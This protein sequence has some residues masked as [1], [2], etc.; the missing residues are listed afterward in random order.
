MSFWQRLGFYR[1]RNEVRRSDFVFYLLLR[2]ISLLI[3]GLFLAFGIFLYQKSDLAL[4]KF[5]WKF[6]LDKN[7]DPQAQEFGALPFI[8]G[9]LVTSLLALIIALPVSLGAALYLTEVAPQRLRSSM[10]F[11]IE[12]LA[13]IPSVV[14][15]LWG[16]FV[17]APWM[18][19]LIQPF[20]GQHLG[21]LPFFQGPPFGIGILTAALILSIMIL[22]TM[23]AMIREVFKAVPSILR[24]GALSLGATRWESMRMAVL[25]TAKPGILGAVVLGL[26][27]AMG[28]TMA[29]TMVIGNRADM[30][31]SVFGAGATMSSVIANEYTDATSDLHLSALAAIGLALF[32]VSLVVNLFARMILQRYRKKSGT[33]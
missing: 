17:L 25:T 13:A 23:T 11:L 1:A 4:Q 3:V 27:R 22:P 7:W 16:I 15:G 20:L 10:G 28:E 6:F 29:V 18:R 33:L 5:G 19:Q 31:L 21:F 8:Y 9:T 2:C 26:G 30:P 24:E 14:Y 12:M 32:I